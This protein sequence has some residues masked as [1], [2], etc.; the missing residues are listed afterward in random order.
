MR[1]KKILSYLINFFTRSKLI[2]KVFQIIVDEVYK[3]TYT[4]EHK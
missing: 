2:F 4:V 1:I 3:K